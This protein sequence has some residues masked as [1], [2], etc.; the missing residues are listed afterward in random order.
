[1]EWTVDSFK[2]F[3]L[4]LIPED[5]QKFLFTKVEN[6]QGLKELLSSSYTELDE[7]L[8]DHMI[9]SYSFLGDRLVVRFDR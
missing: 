2:S 6:P 3:I 1:M 4:P 9:R 8:D 7:F 5:A